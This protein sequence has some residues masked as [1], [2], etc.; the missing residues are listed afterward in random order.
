ML[1][2]R[3]NKIF[4]KSSKK[5]FQTKNL[6][7]ESLIEKHLSKLDAADVELNLRRAK[8][9]EAKRFKKELEGK[10]SHLTESIDHLNS[11]EEISSKLKPNLQDSQLRHEYYE[12]ER[13]KA[14]Q[15]KQKVLD[16]RQQQ[17]KR[18]AKIKKHLESVNKLIKQEKILKQEQQK[19]EKENK[20]KAYQEELK[21]MKE[22]KILRE[23][24]L[25]ELKKR[26]ES[27]KKIKEEKP[28]FVKL[29]ENY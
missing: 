2:A 8:L 9:R 26:D 3:N 28:L 13:Q 6:T 24:E 25:K 29:S 16:Y 5:S 11:I 17:K 12:E 1:K 14:N 20:E 23:K 18:E 19:I 22:K 7:L 4:E 10:L 21:K 15:L 27:L